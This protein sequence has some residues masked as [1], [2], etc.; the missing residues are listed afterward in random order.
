M[1]RSTWASGSGI[2]PF[3]LDRVLRGQHQERLVQ[4]KGL[5]ADGHLPLLHGFQQALCT[6]AG[7]RLISSASTRLAKIGPFL[8]A[9]AAVLGLK[10]H[11]CR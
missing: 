7:A 4:R 10:D 5:L 3:L 2:R 11:A 1:K 6:L 9:K 8:T